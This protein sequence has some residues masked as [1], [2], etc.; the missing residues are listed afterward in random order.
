M[1][2]NTQLVSLENRSRSS[3]PLVEN[4]ATILNIVRRFKPTSSPGQ[5]ARCPRNMALVKADITGIM[6]GGLAKILLLFLITQ[7]GLN[8]AMHMSWRHRKPKLGK[9]CEFCCVVTQF[10]TF[11]F[12]FTFTFVRNK[13]KPL[14]WR[15]RRVSAFQAPWSPLGMGKVALYILHDVFIIYFS[16]PREKPLDYPLRSLTKCTNWIICWVWEEGALQ[17]I[18]LSCDGVFSS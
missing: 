12:L 2:R 4:A 5:S 18:L 13:E 1:F 16:R 7:T 9:I 8:N 15:S 11:G 10:V 3:Y 14:E 17:I 6:S